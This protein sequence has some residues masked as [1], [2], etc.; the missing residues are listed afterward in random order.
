M[1]RTTITSGAYEP[2][3]DEAHFS[4]DEDDEEDEEEE[5]K[6]DKKEDKKDDADGVLPLTSCPV[7][8][9]YLNGVCLT[10]V[11]IPHFWLTVLQRSDL[12]AEV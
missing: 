12:I 7:L 4:D 8:N 5:G 3:E 1:Q 2:T 9:S 10:V 6:D 11:G